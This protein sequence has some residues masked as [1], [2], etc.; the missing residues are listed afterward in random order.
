MMKHGLILITF[1]LLM[2]ACSTEDV[3]Q[4]K[5]DTTIE[6]SPQPITLEQTETIATKEVIESN[7]DIKLVNSE[8]NDNV[9][10]QSNLFTSPQARDKER[11]KVFTSRRL[12]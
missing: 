8:N 11:R 3:S 1:L 7:Q 12:K 10:M 4:R 9:E 2:A 6:L 5:V